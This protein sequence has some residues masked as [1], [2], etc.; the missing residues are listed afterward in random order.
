MSEKSNNPLDML[1]QIYSD[2]WPAEKRPS[3]LRPE[4]KE[5]AENAA[6]KQ[7]APNPLKPLPYA[8]GLPVWSAQPAAEEAKEEKP[9]EEAPKPE[10]KPQIPPFEEYWRRADERVDWTEVLTHAQPNDGETD[11]EEWAFLH[12]RAEKVLSG[13]IA[14]YAE[15]LQHADP[16][17][18]LRRYA[19]SVAVRASG[20]DRAEVT[21]VARSLG[22]D[23]DRVEEHRL[24][25]GLALRCAR[26][27]LALLP[28][29]EVAVGG[30]LPGGPEL[31]VVYPRDPLRKARFGFIDPVAFAESMGGC[32]R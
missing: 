17:A 2:L 3:F 7:P 22:D 24:L 9:A 8:Y 19:E 23:T 5:P 20:S 16:L 6:E 27:V 1:Y 14:A 15:V 12:D 29:N 28:V 18:D 30:S 13:D 21:F 25:A 32:F 10:E 11:P 31:L 4:K 26:D